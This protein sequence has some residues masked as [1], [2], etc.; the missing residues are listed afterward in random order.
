MGLLGII[1]GLAV[2]V[3]LSFRSWSVLVLAPLAD[4]KSVV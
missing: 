3:G 1:L 2:L 4:R